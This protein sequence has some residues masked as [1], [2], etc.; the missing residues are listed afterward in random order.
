MFELK[1]S[2]LRTDVLVLDKVEVSDSDDLV[3]K[4]A[5]DLVV[6]DIIVCNDV[7]LDTDLLVL[8]LD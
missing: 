4:V 6:N 1:P 3:L 5:G 8:D 2:S 7:V